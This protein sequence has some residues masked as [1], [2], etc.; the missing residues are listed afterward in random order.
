MTNL[1]N[2]EQIAEQAMEYAQDLHSQRFTAAQII[3]LSA[4]HFYNMGAE[5]AVNS[6]GTSGDK[7][8]T[9]R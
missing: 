6:V 3:K 7:E 1:K 9:N 8:V 5:D 2:T 4:M